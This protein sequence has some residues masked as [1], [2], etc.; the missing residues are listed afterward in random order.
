MK[1]EESVVES[2]DGGWLIGAAVGGAEVGTSALA[3]ET[4]AVTAAENEVLE[5]ESELFDELVV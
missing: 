5:N 4:G 1:S 2:S 3:P